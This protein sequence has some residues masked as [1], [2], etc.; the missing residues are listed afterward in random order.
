MFPVASSMYYRLPYDAGNVSLQTA[1]VAERRKMSSMAPLTLAVA[2]FPVDCHASPPPSYQTT[3][4]PSP[5][6]DEQPGWTTT[7]ATSTTTGSVIN[8]TW[9]SPVDDVTPSS[10]SSSSSPTQPDCVVKPIL[11][12][13]VTAILSPNF[14]S[15]A[16][17][18]TT[19]RYKS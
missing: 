1:A 7:T 9:P 4:S 2:R 18:S 3:S 6:R 5:G 19:D 17:I 10:P 8:S 15:R 12:F 14:A 16:R 11:K 13:G